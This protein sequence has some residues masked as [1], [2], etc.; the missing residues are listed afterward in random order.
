MI[1]D[2]FFG[3]REKVEP[4]LSEAHR[5]VDKG[6]READSKAN[7]LFNKFFASFFIEDGKPEETKVYKALNRYHRGEMERLMGKLQYLATHLKAKYQ[8]KPVF[9]NVLADDPNFDFLKMS[10]L[11]FNPK[12]SPN[13]IAVREQMEDFAYQ[14]IKKI[15]QKTD[16][17]SLPFK[18]GR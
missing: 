2:S 15:E 13:R 3:K 7:K 14:I 4:S 9:F 11:F 10:D 5:D 1:F 6:V 17:W 12:P 16:E 18:A 8:D